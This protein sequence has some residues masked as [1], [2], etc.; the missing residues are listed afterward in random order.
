[1]WGNHRAYWQLVYNPFNLSSILDLI[2]EGKISVTETVRIL[3]IY[4]E[5]AFLFDESSSLNYL[6]TKKHV[7]HSLLLYNTLKYTSILDQNYECKISVTSPVLLMSI[8]NKNEFFF[9]ES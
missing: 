6:L 3:S 7:A 8:L 9:Y 1:M 5:T 2:Y 4:N